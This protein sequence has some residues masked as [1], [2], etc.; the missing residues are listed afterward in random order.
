MAQQSLTNWYMN[1]YKYCVK[2]IPK[3]LETLQKVIV[4]FSEG[5]KKLLTFQMTDVKTHEI[6]KY[7]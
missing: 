3:L 5:K 2:V 6:P 1:V 4:S 7:S